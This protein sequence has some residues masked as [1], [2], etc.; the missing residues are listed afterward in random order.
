MS[1]R[2]TTAP[3]LLVAAAFV[4]LFAGLVAVQSA[5]AQFLP[6]VLYGTGL[7]SGQKVEAF[8][9][10]KSCGST[11]VSP[12]GE[13]VMQI[14]VEAPCGPTEDAT[15]T[16]TLNGAEA[17]VAPAATW[18]SGGIPTENIA[19]GY[20]LTVEGGAP[21]NPPAASATT[22]NGTPGGSATAAGSRTATATGTAAGTPSDG[23]EDGGG[24]NPA[25]LIVIGI[26]LVAA[27]AVGGY[28]LYRRNA[29]A[30]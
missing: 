2:T 10:G 15:I 30:R 29:A 6:A 3:G 23:D 24:S 9:D 27:A 7:W 28:Y 21:A 18:H 16:F 17:T 5:S 22:G 20:S 19:T 4:A 8:I 11:T 1:K 25:V 12:K 26:V 14:P 13:W